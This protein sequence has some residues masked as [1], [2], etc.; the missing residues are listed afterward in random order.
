[1]TSTAQFQTLTV[2]QSGQLADVPLAPRP[3]TRIARPVASNRFPPK[4]HPKKTPTSAMMTPKTFMAM[5]S[6]ASQSHLALP[7]PRVKATTL[8]VE[9][10]AEKAAVSPTSSPSLVFEDP[11]TMS[12]PPKHWI[13]DGCP[14][15][16]DPH[17]EGDLFGSQCTPMMTPTSHLQKSCR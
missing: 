13:V 5:Q 15:L 10:P 16:Q 8:K 9:L 17:D 1:M 14:A 7:K 12:P 6:S 3:S 4:G 2:H 11:P